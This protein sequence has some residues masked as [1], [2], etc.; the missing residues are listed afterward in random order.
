MSLFRPP[1]IRSGGNQQPALTGNNRRVWVMRE[2]QPSAVTIQVGASDG[3][4]TQVLSNNISDKDVV[5]T[6]SMERKR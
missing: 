6:D 1:R 3:Q 2:G 5:V 4:F